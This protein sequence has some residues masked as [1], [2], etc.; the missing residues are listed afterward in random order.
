MIESVSLYDGFFTSYIFYTFRRYRNGSNIE[1]IL[2]CKKVFLCIIS[3]NYFLP[4][5]TTNV[6]KRDILLPTTIKP[7]FCFCFSN[8]LKINKR[9]EMI[10]LRNDFTSFKIFCFVAMVYGFLY[11][12]DPNSVLAQ[13]F[14]PPST[15]EPAEDI[16]GTNNLTTFANFTSVK[17]HYIKRTNFPWFLNS[18]SKKQQNCNTFFIILF[19]GKY[20]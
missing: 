18:Q 7:H 20:T 17:L 4:T 3:S 9:N 8:K 6:V 13:S 12:S 19:F 11:I 2:K 14:L 5:N 1:K 16:G 10:L 15:V